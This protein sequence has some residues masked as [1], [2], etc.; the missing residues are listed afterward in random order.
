MDE[1]TKE[2]KE[3]KDKIIDLNIL[4]RDL[5]YRT[6]NWKQGIRNLGYREDKGISFEWR[7]VVYEM[8]GEE[9]H[10]VEEVRHDQ[11]E[12]LKKMIEEALKRKEHV[13]KKRDK[14]REEFFRMR[15]EKR[16]KRDEG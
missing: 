15:K 7:K 13:E 16:R 3:L 11:K 4:I 8:D 10:G 5:D 2:E 1:L 12:V 9:L 14:L 6:Y